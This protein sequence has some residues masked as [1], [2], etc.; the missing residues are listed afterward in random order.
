MMLFLLCFICCCSRYCS[1]LELKIISARRKCKTIDFYIHQG[2]WFLQ[3]DKDEP[4]LNTCHASGIHS[5]SHKGFH[6]NLTATYKSYEYPQTVRRIEKT[7]QGKQRN[8]NLSQIQLL[9]LHT[10]LQ[11]TYL[12]YSLIILNLLSCN[13]PGLKTKS[14]VLNHISNRFPPSKRSLPGKS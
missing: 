3:W 4:L 8:Q 13:S 1:F 7:V 9:T 12:T 11:K 10:I 14:N 5:T 6:L 2:G